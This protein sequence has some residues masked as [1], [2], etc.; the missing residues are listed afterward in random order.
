M[1]ERQQ[2]LHLFKS[3][4]TCLAPYGR[5]SLALKYNGLYKILKKLG[6]VGYLV[7]T[8]G[9]RKQTR[10]CHVNLMKPYFSRDEL[11]EKK[12]DCTIVGT[13]ETTTVLL[14]KTCLG[15]CLI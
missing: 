9:R 13:I 12:L 15:S 5:E 14:K 7:E 1:I 4:C 10:V 3:K 11:T 6:L 2:M 8:P